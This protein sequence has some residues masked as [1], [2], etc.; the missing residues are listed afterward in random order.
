MDSWNQVPTV[1]YLLVVRF[2]LRFRHPDRSEVTVRCLDRSF[3]PVRRLDSNSSARH[4]DCSFSLRHLDLSE[5]EWS[6]EISRYKT[7]PRSKTSGLFY[8]LVML[9]RIRTLIQPCHPTS[10]IRSR[11]SCR[12][13]CRSPWHHWVQHSSCRSSDLLA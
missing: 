11:G 9:L 7:A 10:R 2:K 6:E 1:H 8:V 3:L 5:A 13:T 4:P 12:S